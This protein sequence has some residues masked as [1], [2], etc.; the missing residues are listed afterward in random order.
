M[1][2]SAKIKF[3]GWMSSG[4][5]HTVVSLCEDFNH[6]RIYE[7]FW[8]YCDLTPE[9]LRERKANCWLYYENG[10]L[11]GFG[12]GRRRHRGFLCMGGAFI[13]EE[14]WAP[15]EGL[16]SELGQPSKRD[17]KRVIQFKRLIDSMNGSFLTVL[18]TATYNQFA[19]MI[20]RELKASW[21]NGL[22]IAE[23][24]LNRKFEFSYPNGYESRLFENGDQFYMSK[25]HEKAFK[26]KA[27]PKIYK[28]WATATNCRTILATH[29]NT[30]V[31]FIIAEKRRCGS[32]GDFSIA[33][34]P[35]HHGRGIGSVL[36]RAAFNA[37]IDMKVK[38][39]VADYLILNSSAHRLYQKH[40][41]RTKRIYNYFLYSRDTKKEVI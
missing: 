38:K 15:C 20:A 32:L 10:K 19:H 12:L 11:C 35:A 5:L 25:I 7:I 3:S 4:D 18:R 1:L 40:N 41:F 14:V 34:D 27:A 21:I 28:A 29:H 36:L 23:K 39:V 17:I 2:K 6:G 33:V 31:G 22:I 16:S 13:F 24:T 30:P 37:F 8:E 26:E 9:I